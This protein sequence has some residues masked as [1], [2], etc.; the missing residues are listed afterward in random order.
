MEDNI[1]V[2]CYLQQKTTKL[3]VIPIVYL[4]NVESSRFCNGSKS[5]SA[6]SGKCPECSGFFLLSLHLLL[7]VN[8][9]QLL[10]DSNSC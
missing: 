1:T 2:S 9:V 10:S 7:L 8:I 4:L 6:K 3:A 5:E